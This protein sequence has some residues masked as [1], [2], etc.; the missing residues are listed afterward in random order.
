MSYAELPD[1]LKI[2][3]HA[4]AIFGPVS[5]VQMLQ[6]ITRKAVAT[7]AIHGSA[8]RYIL[9][10]LDPAQGARLRFETV[11]TSAAGTCFIIS[12]ICMTETAVHS[13]G[14]DQCCMN[15]IYLC[16]FYWHYACPDQGLT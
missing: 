12:Y 3:N 5:L 8:L 6:S 4:H 1:V 2:V 16:W 9:A 15:C 14:S 10:V 11:V 13:A 7:E